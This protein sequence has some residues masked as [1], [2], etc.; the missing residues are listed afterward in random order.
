MV[1][2]NENQNWNRRFRCILN[3]SNYPMEAI[4]CKFSMKCRVLQYKVC[5]WANSNMV[6]ANTCLSH[7]ITFLVF[8]NLSTSFTHRR[9]DPGVDKTCL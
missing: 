5:L 9:V 1:C 6:K 2:Q 8:S 3:L 7:K 4:C